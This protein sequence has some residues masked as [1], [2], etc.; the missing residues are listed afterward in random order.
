MKR[1]IFLLTIALISFAPI[2]TFAVNSAKNTQKEKLKASKDTN[3][4]V[5]FFK[6]IKS[7]YIAKRIQKIDEKE[8]I[9]KRAS[10]GLYFGLAS[11][12]LFGLAA[13]LSGLSGVALGIG[14]LLSLISMILANVFSIDALNRI[15][16]SIPGEFKKEKNK[17]I[18]GIVLSFI[19]VLISIIIGIILSGSF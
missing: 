13:A 11:L 9:E 4:K 3:A 6:K 12:L 15:K 17:A 18:W 10:L 2:S 7:K 1:Y 8:F 16:K 5:G 14:L 19:T